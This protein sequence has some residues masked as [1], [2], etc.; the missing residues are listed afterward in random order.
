MSQLIAADKAVWQLLIE[1]DTKPK[2][3]PAGMLP[4]D[5][6]LTEALQSYQVSF[7]RL[8]LPAK[9]AEPSSSSVKPQSTQGYGPQKAGGKG[10]K[11]IQPYWNAGKGFSKGK[12]SKGKPRVPIEILKLG[13]VAS[14][15]EGDP[16]CFP[17]NCESGCPDA[18]DGA[19]C[20]RGL[21]I[22]AKC[23]AVHSILHHGKQ[24]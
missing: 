21:H 12:P 23:F 7:T 19:K 8:P 11:F 22:C 18:A 17:Y 20:R 2:R 14:N 4:L 5:T 16:I 9:K 6:K 13:G 15:P 10:K 24:S 1:E 3:T